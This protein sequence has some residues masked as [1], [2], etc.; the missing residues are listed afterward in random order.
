MIVAAPTPLTVSSCSLIACASSVI[1]RRSRRPGDRDRQDRLAVGLEPVDDRLFGPAGQLSQDRADFVAHFLGADVSVLGKQKLHRDHRHPFGAR[2]ADRVDARHRVDHVLDRLRDRR[3]HLLGT[4]AGQ[5]RRDHAHGKVDV[6][7]QV[8]TQAEV[9]QD[10]EH[11]RGCHEH[12]REDRPANANLGNAH[13][14]MHVSRAVLR[15]KSDVL[16]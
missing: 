15:A 4:R 16:L 9:G 3:F 8:D 14:L 13:G 1:S 5:G 6:R 12:P 10:S 7:K 11:D 2:R